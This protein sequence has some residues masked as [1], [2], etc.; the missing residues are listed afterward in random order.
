MAAQLKVVSNSGH[1]EYTCIYQFH[2]LS[3]ATADDL[4][5]QVFVSPLS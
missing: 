3:H 1:P 5:T 4:S 2:V